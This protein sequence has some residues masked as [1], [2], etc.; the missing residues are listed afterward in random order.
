MRHQISNSRAKLKTGIHL[1][2]ISVV[3]GLIVL[4]LLLV[5]VAAS[6]Y[7]STTGNE[8]SQL[9]NEIEMLVTETDFLKQKIASGSALS[10]I[11]IKAFG[12]GFTKSI[13]PIFLNSFPSVAFEKQ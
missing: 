10:T 6:N 2:W 5:Q 3:L 7:L 9:D 12:L 8:L 13:N 11:K 4:V 1:D